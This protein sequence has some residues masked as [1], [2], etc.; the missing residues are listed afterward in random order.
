MGKKKIHTQSIENIT[1]DGETG[2]VQRVHTQKV[3]AFEKERPFVKMYLDDLGDLIGLDP[4]VKSVLLE[5]VKNMG[6]NNAVPAYKPIKEM[7]AK[8]IGVSLSTVNNGIQKL[9]DKGILIRKARGLY[10]VDPNYFGRGSWTDI[11]K[12]KL[13]IEYKDGKKSISTEISRQLGLDF[14]PET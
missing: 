13:T 4:A 1:Y 9:S 6:Y 10:V 7:I 3:G 2:E 12:I 14:E 11:S 5:L 8:N